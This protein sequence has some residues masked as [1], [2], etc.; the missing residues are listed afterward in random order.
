MVLTRSLTLYRYLH[1]FTPLPPTIYSI[2][3]AYFATNPTRTFELRT[4]T[5]AQMLTLG[6]ISPGAR[7]L[8]VESTSGLL[9]AAVLERLG[10]E[11]IVI[12]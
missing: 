12:L 2:A 5:L 1:F 10:G 3:D 4:D 9:T 11:Q 7:V 8:V 6:N